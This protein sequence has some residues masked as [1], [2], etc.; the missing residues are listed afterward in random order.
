MSTSYVDTSGG[1][2]TRSELDTSGS[3]I[4]TPLSAPTTV[5]SRNVG[6]GSLEV[7]WVAATG[8]VDHYD[9][10]VAEDPADTFVKANLEDIE[11]T[12][13]VVPN[14]PFGTTVYVKVKAVDT[15]GTESAFS[16]L[17]RDAYAVKSRALLR[18]S[19][20]VG[21]EI[22]DAAIFTCPVDGELLGLR[23]AYGGAIA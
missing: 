6:N 8:P 23:L 9:L 19:G 11:G 12:R 15:N 13:F 18:F 21:A 1:V 10:Y 22:T 20:P 5:L 14:L 3:V 16:D 17:A 7:T 2:A 4:D